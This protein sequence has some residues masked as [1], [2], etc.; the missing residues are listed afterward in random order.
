MINVARDDL[1]WLGGFR[2]V[3][4]ADHPTGR[5]LGRNRPGGWPVLPPGGPEE[6]VFRAQTTARM[7]GVDKIETFRVRRTRP[8]ASWSLLVL[9]NRDDPVEAAR[10]VA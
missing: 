3:L 6:H 4:G 9:R 8:G 1:A 2:T 10:L 7:T 5:L